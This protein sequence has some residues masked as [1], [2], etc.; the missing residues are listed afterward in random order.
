MLADFVR[1]IAVSFASGVVLMTLATT[2][3]VALPSL[4]ATRVNPTDALREA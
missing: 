3:A 4:R 1:D 2:A